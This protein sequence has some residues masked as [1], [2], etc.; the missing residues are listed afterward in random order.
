[1]VA[2]IIE[3]DLSLRV[4]CQN[5]ACHQSNL[6]ASVNEMTAKQSRFAGKITRVVALAVE[7]NLGVHA[8][9]ESE[10]GI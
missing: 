1:M 2:S 7:G 3:G 9:L 8:K 6:V 5:T 4:E 10:R